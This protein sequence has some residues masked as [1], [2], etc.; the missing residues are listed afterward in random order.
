MGSRGALKR[1]VRGL[2]RRCIVA[3]A[4]SNTSPCHYLVG[5]SACL[6][7]LLYSVAANS[8]TCLRTTDEYDRHFKAAVRRH[9]AT[10]LPNVPWLALKAQALTESSLRAD[11]QS[12][13]GAVGI[14]Q[15]LETTFEEEARRI[16]LRKGNRRNA[17]DSIEVGA[18]YMS[19]RARFWTEPRPV[20]EVWFLALVSYNSGA[21]NWLKTQ[22]MYGGKY[23][24]DLEPNIHHFVGEKHAAE[25]TGYKPRVEYFLRRLIACD[26]YKKRTRQRG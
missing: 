19:G 25:A 8:Q 5:V 21:G 3:R 13:A 18:S 16:N 14:L 20:H 24:S 22:T 1:L 10:D 9:W 12:P 7:L 11:A 23:W 2:A 6:L 26:S 4:T 17:R 15:Q